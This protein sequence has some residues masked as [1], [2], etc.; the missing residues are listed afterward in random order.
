MSFRAQP[1]NHRSTAPRPPLVAR[2]SQRRSN[3]GAPVPAT[4]R[5]PVSDG[6]TLPRAVVA[7]RRPADAATF[8][9]PSLSAPVAGQHVTSHLENVGTKRQL[10]PAGRPIT[11]PDAPL[12]LIARQNQCVTDVV[13]PSAAEESP[14]N[15]TLFT[16]VARPS[17]RR[18]NPGAPAPATNRRPVP[19]NH[20]PS[21]VVARRHTADA[22]TF[23]AASLL[24]NGVRDD[25]SQTTS[26]NVGTKLQ[27][28]PSRRP[29]TN[30][31][32]LV[33]PRKAEPPRRSEMHRREGEE[34]MRQRG[35]IPR[36][37]EESPLNRARPPSLRAIA[38]AKQPQALPAPSRATT[39]STAGSAL[40]CRCEEAP[41][42]RGNL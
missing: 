6:T 5:R 20:A 15:H 36:A 19:T 31:P 38:K 16:L 17:Q 7:R 40:T 14:L 3:P 29:I 4:N 41:S 12:H 18:S 22:A 1:R 9:A 10:R 24:T 34:P 11:N 25:P 13:I 26:K 8:D 28:H 33:P 32:S 27:L 2:P 23:D 42:R 30:S 21:P 37:A 35:V 39:P